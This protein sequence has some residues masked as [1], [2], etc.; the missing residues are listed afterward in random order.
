MPAKEFLNL[1]HGLVVQWIEYQI[2]VLRVEG[3]NP[4]EVTQA[5]LLSLEMASPLFSFAQVLDEKD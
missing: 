5:D 2:P 3:S 4:S 1:H